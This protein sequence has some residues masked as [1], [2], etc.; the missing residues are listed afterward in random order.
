MT[1]KFGTALIGLLFLGG[2]SLIPGNELRYGPEQQVD[3]TDVLAQMTRQNNVMNDFAVAAGYGLGSEGKI[4]PPASESPAWYGATLAGYNYV[5]EKCDAYLRQLFIWDRERGRIKEGLMQTDKLTGAILTA[6]G[7]HGSTI[8]VIAQA[9]G[10]S[11]TMTT[12]LADSYLYSVPLPTLFSTEEKMRKAYRDAAASQA[13]RINSRA[14]A[15]Q[16]VRGYLALCFPQTIEA[17]MIG[18]VNSAAVTTTPATTDQNAAAASV[19]AAARTAKAD[20]ST[21]PSATTSTMIEVKLGN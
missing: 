5:D 20:K 14:T 16:S 12:I 15:Y 13:A 2:C 1:A 3:E 19:K 7:V 9:F 17:K 10:F 21:P 4:A 11:S 6:S 8:Q 18:A